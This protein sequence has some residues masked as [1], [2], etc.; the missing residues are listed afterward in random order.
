M[1]KNGVLMVGD[2]IVILHGSIY[3]ISNGS[4]MY[5]DFLGISGP[6]WSVEDNIDD[7]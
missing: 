7:D 5:L 6:A 3:Q 1:V 4:L 2:T